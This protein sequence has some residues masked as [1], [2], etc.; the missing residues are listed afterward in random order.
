MTEPSRH[1]AIMTAGNHLKMSFISLGISNDNF[2][3]W[4][5]FFFP[6][7]QNWF[8]FKRHMPLA[9]RGAQTHS[10]QRDIKLGMGDL[11]YT[12]NPGG[13][14]RRMVSQKGGICNSR[15]ILTGDRW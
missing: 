7:H 15:P 11:I 9:R 4:V 5:L 13:G 1:D 10:W 14:I 3:N 8:T 12:V 2:K 6:E